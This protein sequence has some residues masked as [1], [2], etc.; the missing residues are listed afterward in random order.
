MKFVRIK[1]YVKKSY[2]G[3]PSFIIELEDDNS[4]VKEYISN[5]CVFLE[6]TEENIKYLINEFNCKDYLEELF[7]SSELKDYSDIIDCR[8]LLEG[9]PSLTEV[10]LILPNAT[11]CFSMLYDCYSLT[12][13]TLLLPKAIDCSFMLSGCSS[14]TEITL[15]LPAKTICYCM[16][17]ECPSLT[18]ENTK[19]TYTY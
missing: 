18:I 1:K 17:E 3:K 12:K 6:N 9:C 13:A 16:L 2:E 8:H 14:L 4:V 19:I 7:N 5:G 10:T 15:S 11:G